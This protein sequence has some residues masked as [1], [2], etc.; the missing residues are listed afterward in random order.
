M[1]DQRV[2][3]PRQ[4]WLPAGVREEGPWHAQ[5][6]GTPEGGSVSPVAA[7][8]YRHDVLDLWADQWR[9]QHARGEV[10]SG[11]YADDCIVGCEPWDDAERFWRERRERLGQFN[12]E[13]P[14]EKTR[15]IECGRCAA[16][17]RQRR[18]Q[19]QPAAFDCLG[20]THLCSTTRHGKCTVRR[21]TSARRLRQ[22]RPAVK[23][24]RRR[25]RHWPIP[26]PGAWLKRV[27]RGHY[28]DDAVP[29][30]GRLLTVVRDTI[31][32]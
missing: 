28:R 27:R 6:E 19:G 31:R 16:A 23:D 25:R 9:R 5:V 18:A 13:L 12:R 4:Q 17:R 32:R 15:R 8:I 21:K 30:H 29:R 26:P 10:I 20:C 3:R 24:T 22:T 14:S 11:R 2:G 7:N 1:G